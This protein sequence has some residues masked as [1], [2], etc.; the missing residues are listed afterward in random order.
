MTTRKKGTEKEELKEK[1][2][3]VDAL[4][5]RLTNVIENQ[6]E[7]LLKR[8]ADME[9]KVNDKIGTIQSEMKKYN[10]RLK[11]VEQKTSDL[12]VDFKEE[13]WKLRDRLMMMEY[14]ILEN[15]IRIRGLPE[16]GKNL[17]EEVVEIIAELVELPLNE[18][19]R[20]CD[21]I[22]RVNSDFARQKNLPRDIILKVLTHK[23]WD[24]IFAS[25]Y[26]EPVEVQGKK[27]KIWRELPKEVIKQRKEMKQLTDRLRL[28]QIKYRWEVPRGISFM[29]DNK[30]IWIKNT[31]Q[32]TE[33]L[34]VFKKGQGKEH[35]N[36]D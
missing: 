8:M 23:M 17:R 16:S 5:R 4:E 10:D 36:G 15:S 19:A 13:N 2:E 18:V 24:L 9:N 32:M 22:Y 31:E 34:R 1:P 12:E 25:H 6:N 14:K 35:K 33:F 21:D 27:I 11:M 26:R 20:E 7:I 30:K 29:S 3:W 28:E